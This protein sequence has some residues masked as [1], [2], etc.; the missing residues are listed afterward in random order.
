MSKDPD[1]LRRM[2]G[3]LKLET[4]ELKTLKNTGDIMEIVTKMPFWKTL[5][6]PF[7]EDDFLGIIKCLK[8]EYFPAGSTIR[9]AGDETTKLYYILEG[10]VGCALPKKDQDGAI[11]GGA[12]SELSARRQ[13]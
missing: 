1:V 9:R 11:I 3:V 10:K 6:N 5:P 12:I 2:V 13:S 7:S 4:K 8:Y